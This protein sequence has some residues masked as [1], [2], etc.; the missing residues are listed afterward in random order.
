M[1]ADLLNTALNMGYEEEDVEIL[2]ACG[3][4][5]DEIE[6]HAALDCRAALRESY[7]EYAFHGG[8]ALP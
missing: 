1:Q 4:C 5:D 6:E 2:M 7:Y 8:G 3:Y